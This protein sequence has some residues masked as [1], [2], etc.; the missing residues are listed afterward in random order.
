MVE[1]D[2][3]DTKGS[4]DMLQKMMHEQLEVS[5]ANN[6]MLKKMLRVHKLSQFMTIIRWVVIIGAAI[7]AFYFVQPLID[8]LQDFY[9]QV[10]G[11]FGGSK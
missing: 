11:I 8:N 2:M 10:D 3:Q 1:K 4:S 5:R 6:H 7:G 9:T